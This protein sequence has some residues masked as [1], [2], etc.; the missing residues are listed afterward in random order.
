MTRYSQ[1]CK[2][3]LPPTRNIFKAMLFIKNMKKINFNYDDFSDRLIISRKE[4]SDKIHGSVRILN[5]ILD[6]TTNNKV[7]SVELLDASKYL[8]SLGINPSILNKLTNVEL[9]FRTIRNGYLIA[10][11]L[12]SGK[13]IVPVPYNVQM[14]SS[15][16]IV[17]N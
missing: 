1:D 5:L 12:K 9:S 15:K 16:Q 10:F 13:K 8:E 14:P 4:E 11:I 17:I 2:I 6:I 7:A 3:S